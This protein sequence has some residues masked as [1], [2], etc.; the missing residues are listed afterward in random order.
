VEFYINQNVFI[1][2]RLQTDIQQHT[3]NGRLLATLRSIDH[4]KTTFKVEKLRSYNKVVLLHTATEYQSATMNFHDDNTSVAT[5]L[6][7]DYRAYYQ[8]EG[9]I[10]QTAVRTGKVNNLNW[11]EFRSGNTLVG[12]GMR[13]EMSTRPSMG[14]TIKA[15][16]GR[17]FFDA[18]RVYDLGSDPDSVN[19]YTY[20]YPVLTSFDHDNLDYEDRTANMGLSMTFDY[21]AHYHLVGINNAP[22]HD[23]IEQ[24]LGF[25]PL[26]VAPGVPGHARM[27]T[28][29]P[30]SSTSEFVAPTPIIPG[31]GPGIIF[32]PLPTPISP[33]SPITV[34]PLP[35][36]GAG[37]TSI[38]ETLDLLTRTAA[39]A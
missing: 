9:S 37:Q 38:Q 27:Q 20:L 39:L 4:P 18:I 13:T 35:P 8:G 31:I 32:E 24:Q 25:R 14:A 23:V 29:A 16:S 11:S 6:W 7:R 34:T 5:A 28:A 17:H 12:D 22:F 33:L 19:I 30:G 21:E 26:T 15:N 3:Q 1:S 2:G 10:G 36:I